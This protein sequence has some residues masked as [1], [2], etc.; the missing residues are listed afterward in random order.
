MEK[1]ETSNLKRVR[2]GLCLFLLAG[3]A[4][5]SGGREVAENGV[6]VDDLLPADRMTVADMGI[7]EKVAV[8]NTWDEVDFY[9]T[10]TPTSYYEDWDVDGD[11]F[12]NEDE[13]TTSFFQLWDTDNDGMIERI[14]LNTALADFGLD[15]AAWKTNGEG[16]LEMA[17]FETGFADTG[18]FETWDTDSDNQISEREYTAG[19]YSLWDTNGDNVL[20]ENEY[21][22]YNTYYGM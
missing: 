7:T 10:F 12:L 1:K 18:W 6:G 14:E 19:V 21:M 17:G 2:N 22:H 5:C 9:T 16:Y 8:A 4:A 15:G 13:F 11:N 20:D 3:T